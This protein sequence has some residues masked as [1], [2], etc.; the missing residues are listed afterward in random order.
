MALVGVS[1]DIIVTLADRGGQTTTLT[2]VTDFDPALTDI[3]TIET[4]QNQLLIDLQAVTQ[5]QIKTYGLMRRGL[6]D[7]LVLPVS[8]GAQKEN[9]AHIT[10]PVNGIPNKSATFDIPGPETGVFKGTSGKASDEVD[11]TNPAL[12]ALLANYKTTGHLT[13]SDGERVTSDVASYA[14]VRS[15]K[16]NRRG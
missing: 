8:E 11:F 16:H 2:F 1:W 10:M 3:T 6:N 4:F 7:A 12:L 14:G 9:N 15:H 13:I 5:L